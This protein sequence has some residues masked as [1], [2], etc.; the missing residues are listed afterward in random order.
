MTPKR[1]LCLGVLLLVVPAS[2]AEVTVPAFKKQHLEKFYW[3][4][5]AAFGDLNRDG[6]PDVVYGPYWWEGPDFTRRHELYA[7][8]TTFKVK[9]T[10]GM[11]GER[12]RRHGWNDSMRPRVPGCWKFREM[13]RA[14][15]WGKR[16]QPRRWRR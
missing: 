15:W 12:R 2:A 10:D 11:R 3:S 8:K 1:L 6:K 14:G 7:P 13:T 9:E 4:E 16:D 5:G